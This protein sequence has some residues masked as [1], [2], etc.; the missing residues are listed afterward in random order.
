MKKA[1][2]IFTLIFL[3]TTV[4]A[5]KIKLESGSL[6]FLKNEKTITAKF[7][8][9]NMRVGKMSEDEYLK[10]RV[11]KLNESESGRGDKWR[12]AWINDRTERFEPKFKELFNKQNSE[13]G[14]PVID[15]EGKYEMI[16]NT[17]FSEPGFNVGV[18]RKSA[19]VS[20]LC[21]FVNKET[22]QEEAEVSVAGSAA[23][24]F[25]GTDFDTG[26]RLQE[27]YA[28]AG[29]ELANFIRKKL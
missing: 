27:S 22:G 3:C 20:L 12:E 25:W 16:V 7:T 5:Q 29:R 15:D 4:G 14:G 13:K 9:E 6:N 26:Y 2:F 1:I 8:Y 24:N 23:A 10:G 28:K 19:S 21:T 17:W 18:A 11:E